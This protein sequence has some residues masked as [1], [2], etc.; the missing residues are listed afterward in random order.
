MGEI[1]NHSIINSEIESKTDRLSDKS[2]IESHVKFS[3]TVLFKNSGCHSNWADSFLFVEGYFKTSVIERGLFKQIYTTIRALGRP[4][5][6][7]A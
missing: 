1:S 6:S 5:M 3:Q 4:E 7:P 2:G